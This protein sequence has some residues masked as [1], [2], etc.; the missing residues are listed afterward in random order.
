MKDGWNRISR[1][2]TNRAINNVLKR[3]LANAKDLKEILRR[4][5]PVSRPG[6]EK[7]Y[8]YIP[9]DEQRE[10]LSRLQRELTDIMRF[11]PDLPT[12]V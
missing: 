12:P 11:W 3:S 6:K 1:E 9:T 7:D 8:D 4:F 10:L 2:H 5:R